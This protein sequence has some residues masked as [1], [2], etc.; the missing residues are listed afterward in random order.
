MSSRVHWRN[1]RI[2]PAPSNLT[3]YAQKTL[4]TKT[5]VSRGVTG[6]IFHDT[7]KNKNYKTNKYYPFSYWD[8]HTGNPQTVTRCSMSLHW[9]ACGTCYSKTEGTELD[10]IEL[11]RSRQFFLKSC[12][13]RFF[14][15]HVNTTKQIFF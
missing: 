12:Q 13:Q 10:G 4:C 2:T 14:D 3:N 1:L 8:C 11:Q 9:V 7:E 15:S 6:K 5:P